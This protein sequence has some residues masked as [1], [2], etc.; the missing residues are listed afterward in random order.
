VIVTYWGVRGSIPAP[1]PQTVHFG[2]NTSCVSIQ[3]DDRVLII[4]AGTGIRALGADLLGGSQEICILLSHLH[5]DHVIGFP[6]FA[7]LYER[8]RRIH[9]LDHKSDGAHWSLLDLF[10]GVRF[11]HPRDL[12]GSA[13]R[14]GGDVLGFLREW[15]FDV[16]RLAM[17]HPGGSFGYRITHA[18]H[19]LVH[20]TDHE[21]FPPRTPVSSFA[22]TVEFCR[23]ADLLSADAQYLTA[24][25]DTCRG[26]GHSSVEQV[27]ELARQSGVKRL[28]LFHHDPSRTE[29]A[30]GEVEEEARAAL[31]GTGI[32]CAAA[33]EGLTVELG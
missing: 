23:G 11:P 32:Q 29:E 14:V 27:C 31:A 12:C 33:H 28:L 8:G 9:L 19:S 6:F 3:I 26:R 10:D 2:G 16:A 1:G 20:L 4:D 24:E 25:L 15:G 21:L 7:P 18:G 30:V 17:N 22:D 5:A 13:H